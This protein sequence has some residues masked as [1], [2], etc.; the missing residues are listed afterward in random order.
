MI[1]YRQSIVIT[2]LHGAFYGQTYFIA[3]IKPDVYQRPGIEN[4]T[5]LVY[6]FVHGIPWSMA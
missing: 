5:L 1:I 2:H 3:R 6:G 4:E